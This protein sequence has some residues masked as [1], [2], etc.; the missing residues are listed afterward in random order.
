[1][2]LHTFANDLDTLASQTTLLEMLL[3][4]HLPV[5]TEK[6]LCLSVFHYYRWCCNTASTTMITVL[7]CSRI[8]SKVNTYLVSVKEVEKWKVSGLAGLYQLL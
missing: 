1:M 6:K 8:M 2:R 3:P 5:I 4:P 7:L